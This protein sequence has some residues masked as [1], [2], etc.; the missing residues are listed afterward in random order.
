LLHRPEV[1]NDTG[2]WGRKSAPTVGH[3]AIGE[4]CAASS[5]DSDLEA[6]SHNPTHGSF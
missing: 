5:M 2:P 4:R 6:F 1:A 3:D